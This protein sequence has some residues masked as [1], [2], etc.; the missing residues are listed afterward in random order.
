MTVLYQRHGGHA[1]ARAEIRHEGGL[2]FEAAIPAGADVAVDEQA[3]FGYFFPPSNDPYAY[4]P[5]TGETLGQLDELG[6]IMVDAAAAA[7]GDADAPLPPVLTYWG[8]FLDHELTARTDREGEITTVEN[9]HPPADP[10]DVEAKLRNARSPRFDLDSVYGGSPL[11]SGVTTDVVKVISGMRHPTLTNKMRV[12]T[13]VDPG[14]LPDNLDEFRDLPRYVQVQQSVR[15]AAIKVAQATMTDP[16]A[17]QAFKDTLPQ[18]ALIGDSRND[19]NLVVAQFHLSFLRF[20]NKAVDFLKEHDTGW[21]PDFTSAQ[22]LTKLHYQWLL[23]EGYLKGLCD[24]A[25]VQNVIDDRASHFFKFRAEFDSRKKNSRLGNAL[26]LE[27]SAAAFRFGHSMVRGGY[28]Y[29]KNFG[30]HAPGTGI[31]D[32]APLNLLFQFTGGGGNIDDDK[33]LP[34]NWVIDWTRWTGV[35]PHDGS[36]GFPARLARKIDTELAPPLGDMIKEGNDEP[37]VELKKLFKHLARR[38]LRRGYNL[39]LPTG[40]AFHA[41]LKAKGAVT[42]D[43]I[44]DVSTVFPTKPRLAGFLSNSSLKLHQRTPLWFYLLAEAEKGGGSRMG[45][46]GS[47]IVASTFV[48]VLL[49][50]PDSALSRGFTPELSPLRAPGNKKIDTIAEWMRFAAVMP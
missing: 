17:L 29:N 11:G 44:A 28:D 45:E 39:K 30:R 20:H 18:R 33:R 37:T 13:A 10:A 4:L 1:T 2:E 31:L 35:A 9:A 6:A 8:Q 16:A 27:F 42:S 23:V 47:F 12:G 36:D 14:P 24:P 7:P 32:V 5:E 15:N 50:D 40:Q 38:N 46:V 3:D 22:T 26:P 25:V 41:Y 43:P 48:G 49:S 19:E 34:K 21:L